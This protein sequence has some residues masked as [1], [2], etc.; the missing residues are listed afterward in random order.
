MPANTVSDIQK[1]ELHQHVDGSIPVRMV[2]RLMRKHGLAPVPTIAEMRRLLQLQ[3]SEEGSL[4]SYL[5]KFHYPL[6]ITQFYENIQETTRTIVEEAYGHGVR[7]LELRYAP[8]IHTYAG[9][10]PRQAIRSVLSG[11]NA[12]QARH[13]DMELGLIII[14]MRQH[15]PHIAKIIARQALAEAQHLHARTGVVGFDLAGAERGNPPALFRDAYDVA[16]RGGLGLTVHAGEDE[17][18]ERILEAIDLLGVDRIGHGCSAVQDKTLLRRLARDR[19]L[20]ECCVTS[21]YQTRAVAP[22]TKH[23]IFRFLECGVP[24]AVCTDNTTVSGTDQTRENRL[25]LEHLSSKEIADIHAEAAGHSFVCRSPL[26]TARGHHM[27]RRSGAPAGGQTQTVGPGTAES[28]TAL[29]TSRIAR[30]ARTPV[31]RVGSR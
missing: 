21:N 9:L 19:I 12:A 10:T 30:A 14:S 23:P 29:R 18:P 31:R 16:R 6:W 2:W 28:K 1:V 17:K 11:M 3:P 20:V 8:A 22:G 25:L 24:V 7:L 4:L 5:D 27:P 13:P 26:F 15:G